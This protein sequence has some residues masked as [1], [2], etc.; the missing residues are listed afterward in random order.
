M[1]IEELGRSAVDNMDA[2]SAIAANIKFFRRA[3]G[4][5][6]GELAQKLCGK[7][8]LV[9]NYE[10]GYSVP[11]IFTLIELANIFDVTL[12]ELVGREAPTLHP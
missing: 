8:S 1:I 11:D 2:K 4:L 6:Q 9:S 12:D 7:K 3:M 10:N 5:T